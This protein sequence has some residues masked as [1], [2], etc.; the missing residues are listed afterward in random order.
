MNDYIHLYEILFGKLTDHRIDDAFYE[1]RDKVLHGQ[2]GTLFLKELFEIAIIAY[3]SRFGFYRLYEAT[4][5]LYRAI[6]SLRVSK[7]RNVREDSVFKFVYENQFVD[8]ILEVFTPDELF[9]FL[10][11]FSYSFNT[12]Y[13]DQEKKTAKVRHI[14][15]LR[16]Y[17]A[18][19]I[20]Q[21]E[22]YKTTPKNF[23]KHLITA[24]AQKIKEYAHQ[25]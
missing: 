16:I 20:A 6:Y 4:L 23:D 25:S 24:I 17:F 15:T 11:K 22:A 14:D 19:H 5:W 10:K 1:F 2:N 9:L 13:I 3:I 21:S 7:G 12:D 8:N 18:D